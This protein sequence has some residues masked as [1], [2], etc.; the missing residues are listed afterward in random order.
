MNGVERLLL[1]NQNKEGMVITDFIKKYFLQIIAYI[2]IAFIYTTD[3]I[4]P[5]VIY[6]ILIHM[7]LIA[8][9]YALYENVLIAKESISYKYI[10]CS[11]IETMYFLTVL[12]TKD[13]WYTFVITCFQF[14]LLLNNLYKK[15]KLIIQTK[16]IK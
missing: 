11:I 1:F 15:R 9:I 14:L 6:S 5:L 4:I 3:S 7:A 13:Y 10:S 12:G 8:S 2:S 16:E